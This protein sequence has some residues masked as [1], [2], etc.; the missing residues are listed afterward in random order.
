MQPQ[1]FTKAIGCDIASRP[2]KALGTPAPLQ[3]KA[4]FGDITCR[5][6]HVVANQLEQLAELLA[7][8]VAMFGSYNSGSQPLSSELI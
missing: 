8:L 4:S 5:Q 3:S 7:Q 6:Q 1:V 2:V